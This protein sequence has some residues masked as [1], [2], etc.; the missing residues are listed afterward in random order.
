M[1]TVAL[2]GPLAAKMRE[3]ADTTGMSLAKLLGDM[4]LAYEGQVQGGYHPGTRLTR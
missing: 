1:L 2:R 4:L 3:L